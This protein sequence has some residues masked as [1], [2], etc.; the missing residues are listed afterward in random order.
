MEDSIARVCS[1]DELKA[2]LDFSNQPVLLQFSSHECPRCPAFAKAVA[3]QG[4]NYEFDHR[5]AL[6]SEA[7]ELIKEYEVSKLP[8]FVLLVPSFWEDKENRPTVY[9]AASHETMRSAVRAQ[10]SAKV[11][12][13]LDF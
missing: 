6:V 8:A 5:L 1:V 9:Q 3:A 13:D 10:C 11:Q 2:L 12:F 7:P 4:E